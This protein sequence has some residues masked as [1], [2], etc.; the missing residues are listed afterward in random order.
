M[1]TESYL[2]DNADFLE[3]IQQQDY[4]TNKLF[5]CQCLFMHTKK[6]MIAFTALLYL[7]IF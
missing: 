7:P 1:L 3:L 6:K 2:Q 4:F 5:L